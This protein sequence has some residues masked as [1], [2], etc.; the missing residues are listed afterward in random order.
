M[1]GENSKMKH[2][3]M[4]GYM[5]KGMTWPGWVFRSFNCGARGHSHKVQEMLD[6]VGLT[7]LATHVDIRFVIG[8][9]AS[10][11]AL[12]SNNSSRWS[13]SGYYHVVGL[14]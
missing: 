3:R 13:G 12:G 4:N 10:L 11:C 2:T 5:Y 1:R 14:T 9:A 7:Q 6:G 8:H